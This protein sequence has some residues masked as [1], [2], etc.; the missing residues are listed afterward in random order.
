MLME[1]AAEP[2]P[3]CSGGR[4]YVWWTG[5]SDP[6]VGD[7][8]CQ[9]DGVEYLVRDGAAAVAQKNGDQDPVPEPPSTKHSRI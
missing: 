8:E 5:G 1:R 7:I 9:R 3:C 6:D 4:A 2:V